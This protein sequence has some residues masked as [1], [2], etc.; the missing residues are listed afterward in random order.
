MSW[1]C[2]GSGYQGGKV[3][4]LAHAQRTVSLSD[5]TFWRLLGLLGKSHSKNRAVE[6]A[7]SAVG[8]AWLSASVHMRTFTEVHGAKE[9]QEEKKVLQSRTVVVSSKCSGQSVLLSQYW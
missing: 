2:A 7:V 8:H 1:L 5:P 4:C 6:T 9:N 3:C